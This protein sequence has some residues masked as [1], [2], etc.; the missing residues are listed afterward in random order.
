MPLQKPIRRVEKCHSRQSEG[1]NLTCSLE[2]RKKVYEEDVRVPVYVHPRF[3]QCNDKS[4]ESFDRT[5]LTHTGSRYFGCSVAGQSDCERVPKQFGTSHVRKDARSETDDLPQV[6]ISKDHPLTSVR[7]ISTRENIDTLIRQA[8]VTP[9]Q[10]FQ[11]CHVSKV[12]RLRRGDAC[13]RQDCGVGSQ[14]NDIGHNGSLVGPSRKIGE[15]N[16][17]TANQIN[18][19]EAINDTEHH[20]TRKGSLIQRGKLN[21]SDNASKISSVDYLSTVKISPDD[22]VGIIG[23]KQFWKARRAIAQ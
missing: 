22:V 7:S 9:N 14:S 11:D 23:Q 13:L 19:A 5:K 3:G 15:G 6:S 4:V 16:A 20:D 1:T 10:E 17:A 18:P 8:K 2:Q 21:G 12:N